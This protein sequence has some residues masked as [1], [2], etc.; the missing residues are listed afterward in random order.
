MRLLAGLTIDSSLEKG[1]LKEDTSNSKQLAYNDT[2]TKN[3]EICP[4]ALKAFKKNIKDGKGDSPEFNAAVRAVDKYLGFEKDVLKQDTASQSDV[5]DMITFVNDAK[6]KIKEAGLTGH[7]YHQTH[8][9]NV[10][11]HMKKIEEDVDNPNFKRMNRARL[12][13]LRAYEHVAQ[14][15][16]ILKRVETTDQEYDQQA[17]DIHAKLMNVMKG[18]RGLVDLQGNLD[19]AASMANENVEPNNERKLNEI[20]VDRDKDKLVRDKS[21]KVWKIVGHGPGEDQDEMYYLECPES[22][23]KAKIRARNLVD[24]SEQKPEFETNDEFSEGDVVLHNNGL[25]IV[26]VADAQADLVGLIPPAMKNASKAEKDK[27]TKMVKNEKIRKPSE[28][29]EECMYQNNMALGEQ[30]SKFDKMKKKVKR[31]LDAWDGPHHK[32]EILQDIKDADDEWLKRLADP[33]HVHPKSSKSSPQMFQHKAAV[34]ELKRRYGVMG[35]S[36]YN[37]TPSNAV[38][39]EDEEVTPV[40]SVEQTNSD[41]ANSLN[42]KTVKSEITS[43]LD[44]RGDQ[45]MDDYVN[46]VKVPSNVIKDLKDAISEFEE[47]AKGMV[48][49]GASAQETLKFYNT[50]VHSFTELLDMLESGTIQ[51]VKRAQVYVSSMMGP[52]LHKLPDSVWEFV[53]Y[54][55]QKRSLKDYL[56][57]VEKF[58]ITG[59]RNTLDEE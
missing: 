20:H 3:F 36:T 52:L 58:P 6:A 45:S 53:T 54:G 18:D 25:W 7:D 42:P 48:V 23:K 10:E 39:Y 38:S 2:V 16:D 43:Q 56:N 55:G 15:I 31:A 37:Y 27:A 30:V 28:E 35:E 12:S 24:E 41:W 44:N 57:P 26:H 29:E 40:N 49:S 5:E 11:K 34:R 4:T 22:G 46:E 13:V 32:D 59:P 47:A 51:D 33:K 50:A 1:Q 8:I 14:A 21:G 19:I 9:D 17:R